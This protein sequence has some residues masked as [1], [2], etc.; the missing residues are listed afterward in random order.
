VTKQRAVVKSLEAQHRLLGDWL[1]DNKLEI[2]APS[3]QLFR[4]DVPEHGELLDYDNPLT[5][6][7]KSIRAAVLK[8]YEE[9]RPKFT[10]EIEHVPAGKARPGW[11]TLGTKDQWFVQEYQDGEKAGSGSRFDTKEAAE[12]ELEDVK[13]QVDE[14]FDPA[15]VTGARAYQELAK[16]LG[17]EE[18]ASK[19]LLA[20]GIPGLRY[21]DQASRGQGHG[22]HN[23]VIWDDSRVPVKETYYQGPKGKA[24]KSWFKDSKVVDE[25][26]EPLPVFHGTARPDRVG[27]RFRKSRATSG[28]MSF[29]TSD[30]AIASS[31]ATNKADTSLEAPS[32]YEGWY[33]MKVGRRE[34]TLDHAWGQLSEEQRRDIAEKL[35]HVVLD[36]DTGEYRHDPKEFG[37][38]GGDHWA[39]EIRQQRGD[40]LKAAKEIWLNGGN[41]VGSEEEFMRVLELGGAKGLFRFDHPHA[42]SPSVY[43]VFLSIRNPLVT[44]QLSDQV[45]GALEKASR[46]QRGPKEQFGAD[47]WD[48]NTQDPKVWMERLQQD[49]RE[50][51]SH[52][53]TSIPDW[54][55]R[56]LKGM[57]YDGIQDTG[58]KGGGPSHAVWI[59][60]EET[61]V[62]SA[63]GNRGTFDP[64]DPNI[65][66]A[67][68]P[69]A[70]RGY[71]QMAQEG[72][73]RLFNIGLNKNADLSTFLHESGHVFLEL[74]GELAARPDAPDQVRDDYAK[75]LKWMGV[76]KRSSPARAPRE[77]GPRLRAVPLRGEG[78]L[79]ALAGAFQR[80]KSWLKTVYR[81][82]A[83]LDVEL[84]DDVRGVFD[85]L[86]ATDREIDLMQRRMGAAE[87]LF[88]SAEE[89][90][91]SQQAFEAYQA[92]R[93]KA[94]S[95][96]QR[97]LE[98]HALKDRLRVNEDWWKEAEAQERKDALE[99][100]SSLP[101]S[102]AFSFLRT[103]DFFL[104][105]EHGEMDEKGPAPKLDPERVAYALGRQPSEKLSSVMKKGGLEPD[106]VAELLGFGTGREMLEA[107]E[108]H[109]ERAEWAKERAAQ[110]MQEKYPDVL[111]DKE[112]LKALVDKGLHGEHGAAWLIKEWE[113]LRAKAKFDPE[114]QRFL[115][116]EGLSEKLPPLEATIRAARLI[117]DKATVRKLDAG[118]ALRAE[119]TAAD[120][121]AKAAARG[122]WEQAA[123]YKQQ[124]LLNYYL[125]RELTAARELRDR[126]LELAAKLS[127]DKARA[128]LGKASPIYRD[129]VDL[130]LEALQLKDPEENREKPLA[131]LGEVVRKMEEDG[132]TVLF[133][134]TLLERLVARPSDYRNMTVEE[135]REVDGA[136]R[137]IKA[138][139]TAV[140]TAILDGK[141]VD[142][143]KLVED[144]VAEAAANLPSLGP[145]VE[146][147]AR[148]TSEKLGGMA[149]SLDGSLLKPETMI[150]WLGGTLKSL[151]YRALMQPLQD[152]KA[153]EVDILN[154]TVQ[155]ILHAFEE[156]PPEAQ[157]HMMDLVDGAKLFPGHRQDLK[158]PTRRY[159]LLMMALHA[160]NESN[161]H[162]LTEGRGITEEQVV[163]AINT[164]TKQEM[165]W[166]QSVWDAAE[167][168]WPEA[169]DLEER[170]SGLAPPKIQPKPLNTKHGTYRGGY[171][172]AVYNKDVEAVGQKQV[173]GGLAA[174]MDPSYTRPSTA[175]SHLKSRVE[176][177]S[178][179]ISLE[180][181]QIPSHLAQVA[182]D[183]AYREALKSVGGLI[184]SPDIQ[185][186]LRE[187]LGTDRR[188]QFLT[189]VKDVGQMRGLEGSQHAGVFLSA[190]R[191]I[192]GN[193]VIA[194]LGFAI[195]NAIEDLSNLVAVLP[196]TDLKASHLA[197]GLAAFIKSPFATAREAEAKSGELR[198][199]RAQL[200]RELHA[201]VKNMTATGV[202]SRKPFEWLRTH[203]FFFMEASDTA[204]ST[205][206][207]VG[208]YRQ[209][210][211][212]GE[213]EADAV[214]KADHTVRQVFPGHSAVDQAAI[215][216]DKG[217]MGASLMFY[218][219]LNTYYNGLRDLAHPLH[220]A[221]S[222]TEALKRVPR[223]GGRLL[224]YAL[225][226]SVLSEFLRGRGREPD[227]DWSQWFLRKMLVGPLAA[228]PYGGDVGAF[229]DSK[230]LHKQ[231]NAHTLSLYGVGLAV[232]DSLLQ[233][234]TEYAN[235]GP[236]MDKKI[237]QML[238]ALGPIFALPT[239]QPLRTGRYLYDVM[240]GEREVRDAGDF[241]SGI[242]Y[243]ERD[244]QPATPFRPGFIQPLQ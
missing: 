241:L 93:L 215:L 142:K 78:A 206:I 227:E 98:L 191:A 77:V 13:G 221:E 228:V 24:F 97:Q 216:R 66:H 106:A 147:E 158:V 15:K 23:F 200:Q 52:A 181:G 219:F 20:A 207:W 210:L 10:Y 199:R 165:D 237:E 90:G 21:L 110:K 125:N 131:S 30:P 222:R 156:L 172:P 6:Q 196:R 164:L 128:R 14:T 100:Y 229:I 132:G 5:E 226:V 60:F 54:V 18:A 75:A 163:A 69:E 182:H 204:T 198:T 11:G 105:G 213:S 115:G 234:A 195:P 197:A 154:K 103:G 39:Y 47:Q 40:V 135:L 71:M 194:A 19:A 68:D 209:A 233:T 59:P 130:I 109:P 188:D 73:R 42:T 141:R 27:E 22:S 177:F 79:R 120:N 53:W 190:F 244:N 89:A 189:W 58:G 152:A 12:A 179:A 49:M 218:G 139:A 211:A 171:F 43:K 124:Q 51:T 122:N 129:G 94:A 87:P 88:R 214:T 81:S 74:F 136:L 224:G 242:V 63:T 167:S 116:R 104:V 239:A 161:L 151:W 112:K 108:R 29:F 92:S 28:P 185:A 236:K 173:L 243:G 212:N 205:P 184:L 65:L 117:A 175:R 192:R 37:L 45:V 183:I 145:A 240:T 102:R 16:K 119:R 178:G 85:R 76:E 162:R 96:A 111:Q 230:V 7:P 168:L 137:N 114:T 148:T 50:G 41:L 134:Q 143:E 166:V 17:S 44:S 86:L 144:L 203:A 201:K 2:D 36:D 46:R 61:Q 157:G 220:T 64:N 99:E 8:L 9:V 174:L 83:S 107:M 1:R 235:D 80:F 202:F 208:A 133:D 123:I 118:A 84:N 31:Y 32:D 176:E 169:R 26:G 186:A 82:I 140:S 159:Q 33:K 101:A 138:T 91:M 48:K 231:Y 70:P 238:R 3:G 149:S 225:A 25:K 150:L 155:P 223:V 160:G 121:A 153:R 95:A 187:R 57:G 232:A 55:T 170:D 127:D 4:V 113:A 67:G 38:A 35:P 126:F 62:K 146:K 193:T 56:A 217:T 180:P 34:V 72:T